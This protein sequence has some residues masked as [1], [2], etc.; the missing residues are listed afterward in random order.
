MKV[1][2]LVRCELFTLALILLTD[3]TIQAAPPP[4]VTQQT[5]V[6][7]DRGNS[8]S[9]ISTISSAVSSVQKCVQI[10]WSDIDIHL[11]I[12]KA[13]KAGTSV[14]E[15]E[16]AV[17]IPSEATT[18]TQEGRDDFRA[19]TALLGFHVDPYDPFDGLWKAKET[20]AWLRP[21]FG[22]SIRFIGVRW[23]TQDRPR[24]YYGII[25]R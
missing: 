13:I 6:M 10:I 23:D 22:R 4:D 11:R 9:I 7:I 18:L 8:D 25:V 3:P 21:S 15:F 16:K 5:K 2:K 14:S 17:G 19:L 20:I 1:M 24:I 12:G